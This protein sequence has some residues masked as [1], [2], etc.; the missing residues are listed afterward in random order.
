MADLDMK[1]DIFYARGLT[2]NGHPFGE[3]AVIHTAQDLQAWCKGAILDGAVWT[4]E[5]QASWLV[6]HIRENWTTW[7]G[8]AD[9]K[10]LFMQK[11]HP[12]ESCDPT[13]QALPDLGPKPE[14]HCPL[15]K[16]S[17][18][19]W[20]GN[21]EHYCQC[22]SGEAYRAA[23]GTLFIPKARRAEIH[24]Q[25]S[26]IDEEL[27]RSMGPLKRKLIERCSYCSTTGTLPDGSYCKCE[28]G[29]ALKEI[30]KCQ[31]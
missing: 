6:R 17:G 25:L 21:V 20:T 26:A 31:S 16:D 30:R 19:I 22:E 18:T 1:Q 3:D 23:G 12:A 4:P 28:I 13:R 7:T 24:G 5:A 9:M 14:I 15:C 10:A 8:T 11:F 27:I 29:E 2:T